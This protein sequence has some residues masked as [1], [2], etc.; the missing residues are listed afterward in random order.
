MPP[1]RGLPRAQIAGDVRAAKGVDRLLGI[2]DEQHGALRSLRR[3]DAVEAIKHAELQRR[4]VLKF[5]DQRNGILLQNSRPQPLALRPGQRRIEAL[6]LVVKTE[7][8]AGRLERPQ[9]DIDLR[10]RIGLQF[11]NE[12]RQIG[13]CRAQR[14]DLVERGWRLHLPALVAA[15]A[16]AVGRELGP[17]FIVELGLLLRGLI[18][19]GLQ[20]VKPAANAL[21]T[22]FALAQRVGRRLHQRAQPLPHGRDAL[23]PLRLEH[24]HLRLLRLAQ[25]LPEV[26]QRG[27]TNRAQRRPGLGCAQPR[28]H[29]ALQRA[30]VRPHLEHAVQRRA[31]KRIDLL[32]PEVAHG[33]RGE[34]AF[35]GHQI[36]VEGMTAVEGVFAQHAL[37]PGVDGEHGRVIHRL[38]RHRQAPG[39]G[40][41]R[42]SRRIAVQQARQKFIIR[43][44]CEGA[45]EALRRLHQTRPNAF[46][47][48]ACGG[49]GEGHHQN[50]LR[51]QRAGKR[52]S[53]VAVA[54]H[55]AQV[56]C[57]DGPGLA[58][59]RAGF[60]EAA[61]LQG[62]GQGIEGFRGGSHAASFVPAAGVWPWRMTTACAAQ[63]AKGW[64]SLAWQVLK[65]P[66]AL[67]LAKSGKV[68][69]R[70]G[71]STSPEVE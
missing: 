52:A 12:V 33:L 49:A 31:R 3:G 25:P 28:F 4:G 26:E 6:E 13:Q 14:L 41:P 8:A 30:D 54:Q 69:A 2:A 46:G 59:A 36:F 39:G 20:R 1:L 18:Q 58:G 40:L 56:E 48:F 68:R 64:N 10:R 57:G 42:T 11:G 45:L 44:G 15:G 62:Q 7:L 63:S 67:R 19:P 70:Q 51:T 22:I 17:S 24:A 21:K 32:P 50:L 71:S 37:A 55:Q 23:G 53:F 61:A 47:Q 27:V 5:V 34:F 66:S 16:Q 29:L 9:P 43:L 60:D 35:V 65:R 38:R